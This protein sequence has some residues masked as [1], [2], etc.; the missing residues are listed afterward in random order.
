M[1]K[2][3]ILELATIGI[4]AITVVFSIFSLIGAFRSGVL[5]KVRVGGLEIASNSPESQRI[6]TAIEQ[7]VT[8]KDDIPFEVEQL[9]NYY[10]Q[11]LSQSKIAFWFSLVFASLGFVAI[12]VAAFF[13]TSESSG[14]T[15]AQFVA[16]TIME[17]VASLFFVQSKNA[18]KSMG[19]F[20][21]KLRSDRL[22]LESRK[23]CDDIVNSDAQDSLKLHLSLH[24]AGVKDSDV[25]AKHISETVIASPNKSSQQDAQTTRASA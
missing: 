6:R 1:D 25:I 18:Q 21:D 22:H 8:G 19:D 15:I 13:Y 9:T 11:I 24:Y 10:S 4:T 12:V 20:F 5:T 16:G 2:S 7:T 23:L 17:A 14:T 3:V